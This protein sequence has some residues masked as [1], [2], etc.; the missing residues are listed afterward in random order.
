MERKTTK[1]KLQSRADELGCRIIVGSEVV[2]C[3]PPDGMVIASTDLHWQDVYFDAWSSCKTLA[4]AC[5]F[6]LE[7][8]ADGVVNCGDVDCEICCGDVNC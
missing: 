2:S 5:A 4:E 3:D 1:Q 6:L 8:L 7:D